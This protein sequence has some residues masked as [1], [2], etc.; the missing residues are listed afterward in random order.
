[1][2]SQKSV[3]IVLLV[4]AWVLGGCSVEHYWGFRGSVGGS[5]DGTCRAVAGYP[6]CRW[7]GG[8]E[9]SLGIGSS[10]LSAA[11]AVLVITVPAGHSAR[12]TD[13][14]ITIA[15]SGSDTTRRE[16]LT[17]GMSFHLVGSNSRKPVYDTPGGPVERELIG[18]TGGRAGFSARMKGRF[19]F[20]LVADKPWSNSVSVQLPDIVIDGV[21]RQVPTMDFRHHRYTLVKGCCGV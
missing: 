1:M 4:A 13:D 20:K 7:A 9:L 3:G 10:E 11:E 6:T 2:L 18:S 15:E 17:S 14:S 12:L 16:R 8:V 19:E 5:A 21:R